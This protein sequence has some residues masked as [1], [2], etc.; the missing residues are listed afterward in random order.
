ML[1][2]FKNKSDTLN[3][4]SKLKKYFPEEGNY[5]F[6]LNNDGIKQVEIE[7]KLQNEPMKEFNKSLEEL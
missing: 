6:N 2:D 7:R 3:V 1:K 4:N 5:K